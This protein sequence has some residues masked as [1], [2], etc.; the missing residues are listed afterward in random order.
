[1]YKL[2]VLIAVVGG[3]C[4]QKGLLKAALEHPFISVLALVII[5]VIVDRF[6]TNKANPKKEV[7]PHNDNL[8]VKGRLRLNDATFID[9]DV[10]KL[11]SFAEWQKSCKDRK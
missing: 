2:L 5:M 7:E 9:Q 10:A 4:K 3:V 11:P 6:E 1:M 8:Q